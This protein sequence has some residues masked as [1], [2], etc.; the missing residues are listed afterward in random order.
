MRNDSPLLTAGKVPGEVSSV[1]VSR[2]LERY[3]YDPRTTRLLRYDARSG[4]AWRRG[5][6]PV[7]FLMIDDHYKTWQV[8]SCLD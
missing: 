7:N 1:P 4:L 3:G 5:P 6:G 8:S 2:F